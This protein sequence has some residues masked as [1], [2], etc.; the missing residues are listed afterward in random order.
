MRRRPDNERSNPISRTVSKFLERGRVG[1]PEDSADA[2][3]GVRGAARHEASD[4]PAP[5]AAAPSQRTAGSRVPAKN[6]RARAKHSTDG[7]AAPSAPSAASVTP[8]A[9]AT[10]R[11]YTV[12]KGDSLSTIAQRVYGRS[13]RWTLIFDA[14]RDTISDPNLIHPGQVL[15]LPEIPT[16]H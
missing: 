1:R 10:P 16:L 15:V 8:T 13:D 12:A 4:A 14:N 5:G 11:R 2:T 9:T 6:T 7:G 3:P